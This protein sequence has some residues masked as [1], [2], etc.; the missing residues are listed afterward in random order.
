MNQSKLTEQREQ[1]LDEI[2]QTQNYLLE[3]WELFEEWESEQRDEELTA[4]LAGEKPATN[5]YPDFKKSL[6]AI[7]DIQAEIDGENE[8]RRH[9]QHL[10][11]LEIL[12]NSQPE[13]E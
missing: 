1:L 11:V 5:R 13:S 2:E 12:S 6:Q 4:L 9:E 3:N 7:E 10:G 8:Q